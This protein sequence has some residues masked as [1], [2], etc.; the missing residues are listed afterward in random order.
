MDR[1][2]NRKHITGRETRHS[3]RRTNNP[4]ASDGDN[5]GC[6]GNQDR[7]V[8]LIPLSILV[9]VSKFRLIR[10]SRRQQHLLQLFSVLRREAQSRGKHA[11]C[12]SR[13]GVP[14][15]GN[16]HAVSPSQ[17]Q[18]LPCLVKTSSIPPNTVSE[19]RILLGI[20][21]LCS[22]DGRYCSAR[23]GRERTRL[24]CTLQAFFKARVAVD[25]AL[26]LDGHGDGA[27]G[28][29]QDGEFAGAGEGGV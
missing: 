20:S 5:V 2:L 8:K 27:L 21:A 19:A 29:D 25:V 16:N 1:P 24:N 3:V 11:L 18:P 17:L 7:E 28:A 13:S 9:M 15:S 6:V 10:L 4:S 12:S 26:L 23:H 22:Q 14:S